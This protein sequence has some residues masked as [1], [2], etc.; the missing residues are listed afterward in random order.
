[1]AMPL[2]VSSRPHPLVTPAGAWGLL[3]HGLL[4]AVSGHQSGS[5]S[6]PE[7]NIVAA[8]EPSAFID[9]FTRYQWRVPSHANRHD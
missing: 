9:L 2:T 8:S 5:D 4:A 1:M 6:A 7:L 3:R